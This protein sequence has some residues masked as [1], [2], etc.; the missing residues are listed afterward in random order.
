MKH[1]PK[2]GLICLALSAGVSS[3]SAADIVIAQP[4]WPSAAVTA[5]VMKVIIEENLGLSVELQ[6]GNNAV[7]FEAM[8]GGSMHVHPE[9]WLPN[10]QNFHDTYV[11]EKKTVKPS[12]HEVEAVIGI[13]VPRAF[14]EANNI[15]S[16]EDLTDPA[17]AALF[18]TDGDGKGELY[19]GQTGWSSSNVERIRAKSY[20]YQ[21]TMEMVEM[22]E[23]LA[24]VNLNNASQSGG[25]WVGSCYTPHYVFAQND[26][27]ILK[28][29]EHDA[30]QWNVLQP[31]DDPNWLENSSAPVGWPAA[32]IRPYFA[33]ALEESFPEVASLIFNMALDSDTIS[34][35]TLAVAS[36][37]QDPAEYAKKWVSDNNDRV[38]GWLAD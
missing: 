8:D 12:R 3:A 33:T 1:L 4:N 7:I 35:M 30:S 32:F 2:A 31:T 13:C 19:I 20:G 18:D 26:L 36:E 15:T 6:N 16:I 34:A 29:P 5:N 21:E 23:A 24:Y 38:L 11:E 10:H 22:D 9:V 14:G 17:I 27:L 37:K 28:E 25:A